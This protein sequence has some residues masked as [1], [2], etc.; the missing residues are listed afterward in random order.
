MS[1]VSRF[2]SAGVLALAALS[3][4]F[5]AAQAPERPQLPGVGQAQSGGAGAAGK[6][7]AEIEFE[8][9]MAAPT[10][11]QATAEAPLPPQEEKKLNLWELANNGGPLMYPIFACSVLVV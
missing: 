8:R 6:T 3:T 10:A 4:T 5:A 11:P 9:S 7:Q 1:K 2:W